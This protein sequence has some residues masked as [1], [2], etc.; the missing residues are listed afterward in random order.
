VFHK[1]HNPARP[2]HNN[3]SLL[4]LVKIPK[5]FMVKLK[6]HLSL[7]IYPKTSPPAS[8]HK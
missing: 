5:H 8:A 6:T 2:N 3:Q 7:Q 1:N 4:Q